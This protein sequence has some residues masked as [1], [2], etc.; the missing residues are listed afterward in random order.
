M[1]AETLDALRASIAKWERNAV[2]E[3]LADATMGSEDCPLCVLFNPASCEGCPVFEE[4][5]LDCCESTP[6]D[7]ACKARWLG[8]IDGFEAAALA[9]VNFLRSLLPAEPEAQS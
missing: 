9:E 2:V 1:N 6:Y 3:H 8:D 4:T 5:E 7:D